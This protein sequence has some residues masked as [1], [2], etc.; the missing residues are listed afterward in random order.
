MCDMIIGE[1][2]FAEL[3]NEETVVIELTAERCV[4][5]WTPR[6]CDARENAATAELLFEH[7]DRR[8][9]SRLRK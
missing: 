4:H 9:I 8:C 5:L 1:R 7:I 6:A 2:D 3:D